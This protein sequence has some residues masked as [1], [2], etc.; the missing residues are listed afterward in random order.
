MDLWPWTIE[1]RRSLLATYEQL[2][3]DQWGTQSLSEGWTVREVLAHLI[4]ATRPPMRRYVPAV[5][6]ARGNF[7]D[8]NRMLAVI[9]GRRPVADLLSEYRSVVEHRFAPPGWPQAAPLS[10][11][12]L[13][14]L[15]VRLPLGLSV[16]QPGERYE[17]VLRLLFSRM[18]RSFTRTGRPGVRWVATDQ[19]FV[20]GSGPEV[21]GLIADLALTAAGRPARLDQLTGDGVATLRTWLS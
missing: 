9:D 5:I 11:I 21:R 20:H 16:D 17:P 4:L 12:V 7:D 14:S 1:A 13:H 3:D 18:G 19:E 8:A 6:R 10:D 15:D 2:D